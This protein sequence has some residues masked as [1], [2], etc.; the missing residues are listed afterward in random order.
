MVLL[1]VT[2]RLSVWTYC[3]KCGVQMQLP[4]SLIRCATRKTAR[5]SL[6]ALSPRERNKPTSLRPPRGA[7]PRFH[8]TGAP[9]CAHC[10]VHQLV[11]V[12]EDATY[13]ATVVRRQRAQ[14]GV[15]MSSWTHRAKHSFMFV[16][17]CN[18][19]DGHEWCERVSLQQRQGGTRYF[20]AIIF[21]W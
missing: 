7:A 11:L 9:Q 6:Q 13:S 5:N 1:S 8:C 19:R 3:H 15:Q 16:C 21:A 20:W 17:M 12:S 14:S 18:A 10:C 4:H 2:V